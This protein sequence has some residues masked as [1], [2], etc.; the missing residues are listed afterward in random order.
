M[1]ASA[2]GVELTSTELTQL[3]ATPAPEVGP[4]TTTVTPTTAGP[5][6]TA[7]ETRSVISNWLQVAALGGDMSTIT[8][9]KTLKE[10][11]D[12]TGVELAAPFLGPVADRYSKGFD[13]SPWV[14][15]GAIPLAAETDPD[16]VIAAM[17]G[18]MSLADAA[19]KYSADPTFVQS[20]GVLTF[21]DGNT[22]TDPAESEPRRHQADGRR[23]AGR[24]RAWSPWATARPS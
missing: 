19:T 7:D 22:C 20:S 3:M 6:P 8:T 17:A 2:N 12:A 13:G 14:C 16:E 23:Q 21:Q 15:L 4:S 24:A 1:V 5:A 10:V 11:A 18:G 9:R